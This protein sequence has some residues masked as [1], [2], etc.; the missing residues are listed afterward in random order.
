MKKINDTT[1]ALLIDGDNAAPK[2]LRAILEE[3]SKTGTITIRRIYGDW[4]TMGM[5]GWKDLLNSNAI[6]PV[7]QFAYT[8]GKN[9]TDSALI[10]DAMDILHGELVDAFCIVSSDSDYTRL[11]TRLR[12]SGL[13]VMGV[14]EK[15]TPDAF[16]KACERFIYVE[17][18]DVTE[19]AVPAQPAVQPIADTRSRSGTRTASKRP[20]APA[21]ATAPPLS[22]NGDL[23]RK[24]R[25]AFTIAKGEEEE[26]SLSL[27]GQALRRLDPGFDPRSYGHASLSSMI[28]ALK[29][30]LETRR[31]EKGN[32]VMVRFRG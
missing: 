18:L 26:A 19:F 32:T 17:N 12:E 9:S 24:L 13:F 11:A 15:K 25:K 4:T 2:R 21:K 30:E 16:V 31:E 14:G 28:N 8:K 20:A 10:I 1:I 27:I 7:Q 3:V 23:M 6:Q 29:D 5:S 22:Q